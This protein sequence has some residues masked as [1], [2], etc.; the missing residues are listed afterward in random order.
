MPPPTPVI[1][2]SRIAGTGPTPKSS[3]L[4]APV[5]QNRPSPMASKTSTL[6][7]TRSSSGVAKYASNPAAPAAAR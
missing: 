7:R 3:A 5:T 2:P 1:A 6:R 4:L